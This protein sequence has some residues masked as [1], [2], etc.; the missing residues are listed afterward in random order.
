MQ[1]SKMSPSASQKCGADDVKESTA[2]A[3]VCPLHKFCRS[4]SKSEAWA[5]LKNEETRV[6][7]CVVYVAF[8]HGNEQV[9]A[10]LSLFYAQETVC[11]CNNQQ[12]DKK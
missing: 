7:S 6:K 9:I 3:D 8:M 10:W 11:A 5:C 4:P 12:S 2:I 1:C